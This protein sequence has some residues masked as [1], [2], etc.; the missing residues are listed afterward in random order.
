MCNMNDL[1]HS[2]LEDVY[3]DRRYW[4]QRAD[5]RLG[6]PA[7]GIH[8]PLV[9]KDRDRRATSMVVDC[10]CNVCVAVMHCWEM[11]LG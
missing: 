10:F 6:D 4:R 3:V 11:C 8:E 9:A 5:E 7:Q 1:L 2:L